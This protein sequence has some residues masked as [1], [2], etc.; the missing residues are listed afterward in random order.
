MLF[1][2]VNLLLFFFSFFSFFF[3]DGRE[4]LAV[5]VVPT[6]GPD[7]VAPPAPSSPPEFRDDEAAV[8]E[9]GEDDDVARSRLH[10]SLCPA[11]HAAL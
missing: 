6:A 9:S 8:A 11:R 1:A 4:A 10:S 7:G 3:R 5:A 2:F